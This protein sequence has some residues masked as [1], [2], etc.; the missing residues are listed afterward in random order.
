MSGDPYVCP[1]GFM[2]APICAECP[3]PTGY[4]RM[5]STAAD[6]GPV[7]VSTSRYER[8]FA[9]LDRIIRTLDRIDG[10]LDKTRRRR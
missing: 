8:L 4:T 6:L 7:F 9:T 2:A 1:H 5:F 3:P 10:S